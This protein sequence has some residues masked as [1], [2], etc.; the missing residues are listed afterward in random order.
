MRVDAAQLPGYFEY[1]SSILGEAFFHGPATK[2]LASLSDDGKILGVVLYDR[3]TDR[4]CMIH[5]ASN[6]SRRWISREM[7]FWTFYVPF[8]QFSLARVTGIV[9]ED[10]EDALRFDLNLGF[11]IEG[12]VR[13]IFPGGYDG[14]LLGMLR[15]EC[16]FLDRKFLRK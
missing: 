11:V 3:I 8:V 13:Q 16:R 7:L 10:N 2:C 12:R 9:R 1:A 6:G 15:D 5:V 4:D 14:I